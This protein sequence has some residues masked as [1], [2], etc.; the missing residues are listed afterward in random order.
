MTIYEQ[1]SEQELEVLRQRAARVARLSDNRNQINA[2]NAL[3]ITIDDAHYAINIDELKAVY[4]N[5]KIIA[6]PG[7]PKH[8]SGVANIRGRILPVLELA[9]LLNAPIPSE[10]NSVIVAEQGDIT[11]GFR[12]QTVGDVIAYQANDLESI[13]ENIL[14]LKALLPDGTGLLDIDAILNDPALEV[15]QHSEV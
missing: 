11:L 3:A 7:T 13:T 4:E 9:H 8:I 14:Y 1:F 6:I 12:V 15:D 10:S 5:V 2:H